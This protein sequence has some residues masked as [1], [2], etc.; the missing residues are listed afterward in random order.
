MSTA[1]RRNQ[2]AATRERLFEAALA[3]LREKGF[4]HAQIDRIAEAAGVVRGTFYFH[5]PTREHVLLELQRRA[6]AHLEEA[7]EALDDDA[8]VDDLLAALDEGMAAAERYVGSP[9]LMGDVVAMYVRP[10]VEEEFANTAIPVLRI[11]KDHLERLIRQ[12]RMRSDLHPIAAAEVL[13][14]SL[15]GRYARP[16]P[17]PGRGNLKVLM[18]VFARGFEPRP[19]DE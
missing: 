18:D 15:L 7:L 8:S 6:Q 10:P 16:S 5:F 11:L 2:R 19:G 13:L 12:G 17:G 3:E 14:T 4:T 1:P 9:A